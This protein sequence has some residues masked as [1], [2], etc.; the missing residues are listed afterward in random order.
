MSIYYGIY[1]IVVKTYDFVK[2]YTSIIY[3]GINLLNM[4]FDCFIGDYYQISAYYLSS[5]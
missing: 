2:I 4:E 3:F 5:I 1:Y